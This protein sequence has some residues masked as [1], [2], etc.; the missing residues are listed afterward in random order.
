MFA[1]LKALLV[2]LPV[3]AFASQAQAQVQNPQR[4][5]WELSPMAPLMGPRLAPLPYSPAVPAAIRPD[6]RT[7]IDPQYPPMPLPTSSAFWPRGNDGDYTLGQIQNH[8]NYLY[9]RLQAIIPD[10]RVS[11]ET[12]MA[13]NADYKYWDQLLTWKLDRTYPRANW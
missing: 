3:V 6:A 7:H 9:Q 4:G 11:I 2:I 1:N 8:R 12:L 13:V 10:P 5:L